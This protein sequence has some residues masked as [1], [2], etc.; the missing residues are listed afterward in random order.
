MGPFIGHLFI[1]RAI[2]SLLIGP[3]LVVSC[4][5]IGHFMGCLFI[6]LSCLVVYLYPFSDCFYNDQKC[7]FVQNGSEMLFH[8]FPRFDIAGHTMLNT[9]I[10]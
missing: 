7:V 6:I 5:F 1:D 8:L 3:F 9:V 4:V 10:F 2:G